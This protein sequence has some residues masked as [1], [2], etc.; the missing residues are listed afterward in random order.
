[1]NTNLLKWT[2]IGVTLTQS[3]KKFVHTTWLRLRAWIQILSHSG[4]KE[5]CG[6]DGKTVAE[7]KGLDSLHMLQLITHRPDVKKC[8][9]AVEK[10]IIP[11]TLTYSWSLLHAGSKFVSPYF[12]LTP[13]QTCVCTVWIY[14]C[15]LHIFINSIEWEK[16]YAYFLSVYTPSP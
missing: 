2:F 16:A 11:I 3:F 12:S 4:F 7:K 14:V 8:R 6:K 1:M 13:Y 15:G 10:C 5:T 9:N